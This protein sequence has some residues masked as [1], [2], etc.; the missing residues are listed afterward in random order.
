MK[1]AVI[2]AGA[3]GGLI[4][5]RLIAAGLPVPLVARRRTLD[6][7]R[8]EGLSVEGPSG[9][10]VTVRPQVTDDTLSLGPQDAVMLAV[11]AP[12][13]PEVL[14]LL[15]PLLGRETRLVAVVGG[16][17]WWYPAGK[18]GARPLA[19]VDPQGLLWNAIP[20]E[21][22]VGAVARVA[23]ERRSPSYLRHLGGLRL[24]LGPAVGPAVGQDGVGDLATLF[25]AGGF[26][27]VAVDDIRAE[28]WAAL[29]G[30]LAF[31]ALGIVTGLP[32]QAIAGHAELRPVLEA[33]V[34]ELSGLAA[35]LGH[36]ARV[37]L[38][39]LWTLAQ[40]PGRIHPDLT[41]D[42]RTEVEAVLDAP[43]ELAD[44]AGVALPTVNTLRALVRLKTQR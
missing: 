15:P 44:R 38:D 10:P 30:P 16:V 39:E 19:S 41:A 7:L 11:P 24:A 12:A 36:P 20:A 17:P 8:R 29:T 43:L 35:A 28:V 6:T 2:G 14:E 4:A 33:V 42:R 13:L 3:V 34:A 27:A 18:D 32:P 25:G 9:R 1:I 5:A 31:G 26:N 37:G 21:R 22:I 40:Q 23:V